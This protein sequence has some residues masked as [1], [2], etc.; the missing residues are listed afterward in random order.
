MTAMWWRRR[1]GSRGELRDAL[2]LA[3]GERVLVVSPLADGGAA[4][5]TDRGLLI[6][7]P[8]QETTR[9]PWQLLTA[10]TWDA[11]AGMLTVDEVAGRAGAARRHQLRPEG[12]SLLPETVRERI[13]SSIV[14]SRHVPLVG[15]A[16]VHI[17][18]RRRSGP[19]T[20]DD[21]PVLEWQL[22]YDPG[23]DAADSGV[24][25]RAEQALTELQ[26]STA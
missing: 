7:T 5:A 17:V 12:A 20:A 16:G 9:L 21:A 15:R 1:S 23:V 26:R 3:P 18:G 10:A 11:D 24:R 14:V 6:V 19:P 22:L 25:A 4:A 13:T 2:A 8:D